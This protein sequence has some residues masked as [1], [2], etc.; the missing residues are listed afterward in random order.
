MELT[1]HP[2]FTC[3]NYAV[4][5][6][7]WHEGINGLLARGYKE[8]EVDINS[9]SKIYN[10]FIILLYDRIDQKDN[11]PINYHYARFDNG[12]FSAKNGR[13]GDFVEGKTFEEILHP[14]Y[15][16]IKNIKIFIH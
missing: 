13:G 1:K 4:Q 16:Q 7:T 14:L 8:V 12:I 15:K 3:W 10:H 5:T 11:W 2:T 9:A 6:T